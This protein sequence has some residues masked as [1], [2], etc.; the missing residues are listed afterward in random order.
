M[1]TAANALAKVLLS[2]GLSD[3]FAGGATEIEV[4]A[5][6]VRRLIKALDDRYPGLGR[7]IETQMAVA[8]DGEIYQDAF[9]EPINADSEVCFLPKIGGG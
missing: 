6:S 2:F 7:E 3:R 4:E 8:I 5:S 1:K 9:L